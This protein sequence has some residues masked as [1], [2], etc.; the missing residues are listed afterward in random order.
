MWAEHLSKDRRG[1]LKTD[2]GSYMKSPPWPVLPT[3]L[4]LQEPGP[5]GLPEML[6]VAHA[7]VTDGGCGRGIRTMGFG[8]L[9]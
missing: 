4:L 8:C 7:A 5:C 3:T 9:L 2:R 1:M 6:T